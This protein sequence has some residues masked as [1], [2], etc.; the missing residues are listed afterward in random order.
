VSLTQWRDLGAVF[1]SLQI[2]IVLLAPMAILVAA[3]MGL[4]WVRRQI[5]RFAPRVQ[6][7]FRDA[8]RV[9]DD[10]SRKVA[11]PFVTADATT[12]RWRR[13]AAAAA[14]AFSLAPTPH[15]EVKP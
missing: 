13:T 9:T 3:L 14:R 2:F 8:S 10:V 6:R 5:R 7:V 11:A 4:R 1:I 15:R 12:R